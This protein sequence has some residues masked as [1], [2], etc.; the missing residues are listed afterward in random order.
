MSNN[1]DKSTIPD[2]GGRVILVTGGMNTLLSMSSM[3]LLTRYA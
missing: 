2:L 1:F 3:Q